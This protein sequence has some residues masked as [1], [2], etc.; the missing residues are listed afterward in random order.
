MKTLN[1]CLWIG[2]KTTTNPVL[3]F[4][5]KESGRV[6][7]LANWGIRT[8]LIFKILLI[9]SMTIAQT[10]NDARLRKEIRQQQWEVDLMYSSVGL[11][12]HKP[13]LG[14]SFEYPGGWKGVDLQIGPLVVGYSQGMAQVWHED[15]KGTSTGYEY[16]LSDA[17]GSRSYYFGYVVPAPFATFGE[18]RS[19]N[20]VFRGHPIGQ[21]TAGGIRMGPRKGLSETAHT[22]W[23]FALTPGYR[24]R[25]PYGSIDL[26]LE[27]RFNVVR[28]G[29]LEHAKTYTLSPKVTFRLEGLFDSFNP[30]FERVDAT[31]VSV[32]SMTSETHTSSRR[33]T[34]GSRTIT[35]T[36]TNHYNVSTKPNPV[37]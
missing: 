7:L 32:E 5:L 37:P 8:L 27:N 28:N 14:K 33:N 12:F 9:S 35:T 13:T 23:Q 19:Y 20:K 18:F 24:V 26:G 36:T 16:G 3:P 30:I 21:V 1:N 25:F 17:L 11:N 2:Q 4:F 29:Y 31:L 34:D 10:V 6:H 22:A 15:W